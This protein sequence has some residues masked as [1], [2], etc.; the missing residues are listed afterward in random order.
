MSA[1]RGKFLFVS[2]PALMAGS[3][4]AQQSA[5]EP[6]GVQAARTAHLW[7]V[8]F[9]VCT[10][11]YVLVIAFT[12][13]AVLRNRRSEKQ[14]PA[15][16]PPITPDP[17]GEKRTEF[18]VGGLMVLTT[19][20]LFVL[21]LGEFFTGRAIGSLSRDP[22]PLTIKVIGHQW[23][24]E[25][26]YT[27]PTPQNWVTTANEVHVPIGRTVRVD[28]DSGDVIHSFWPANF[29][30]K[31]DAIPGHP[32][33]MFFR[34]DH[35]GTF[36]GQCAEYCGAQHANMR[37]AIVSQSEEDFNSWI[38]MARMAA[39]E[40]VFTEQKRGQQVFLRA[41]CSMCHSIAGTTA[42]GRVGPDLT[43]IA[44][45]PTLG[46]GAIRMNTGHIAGWVLDPQRIKPG[47]RM[48]QNSLTPDDLRAL[49]EYLE[50]LK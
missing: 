20:I 1:R 50:S 16:A 45:R 10:A 4:T 37:F 9:W 29:A 13:L 6:M 22:G 25:V 39:P 18:T 15:A 28:L 47:V 19:V 49:L 46:A 12:L 8:F 35:A 44:S 40:P 38:R 27:D 5:L 41:S 14:D 33:S 42:G 17:A 23:W 2:L 36:F 7:W 32:T 3:A 26:I 11:V 34:A 48:P 24:W 31:K 21:L 43:H 30:G